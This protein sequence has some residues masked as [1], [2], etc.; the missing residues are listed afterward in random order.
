MA[1]VNSRNN[2]IWKFVF[3]G[4]NLVHT[5]AQAS[6]TYEASGTGNLATRCSQSSDFRHFQDQFTRTYIVSMARDQRREVFIWTF[7]YFGL[8]NLPWNFHLRE[9]GVHLKNT[10]PS[11]GILPP[12][13]DRIFLGF[14]SI[15]LNGFFTKTKEAIFVKKSFNLMLGKL[16]YVRLKLGAFL[17]TGRYFS[18]G[19]H[20]P[21]DENPTANLAGRGRRKSK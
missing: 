4:F 18:N 8:Q 12:S 5:I 19:P 15:K 14:P 16:R 2:Q 11:H 20:F 10:F 3:V 21:R 1:T 6:T 13:F 9:N 17:V 7:G